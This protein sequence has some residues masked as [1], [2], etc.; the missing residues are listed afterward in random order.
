MAAGRFARPRPVDAP[1]LG[2]RPRQRRFRWPLPLLQRRL[3]L[4]QGHSRPGR[5]ARQPHHGCL[6]R[7]AHEGRGDPPPALAAP[8]PTNADVHIL[9]NDFIRI[10]DNPVEPELVG[11]ELAGPPQP[12]RRLPFLVLVRRRA[13]RLSGISTATPAASRAARAS[14]AQPPTL[15]AASS[16]SATRQPA[17]RPAAEPCRILRGSSSTT[18]GT[19]AAPSS[20]APIPRFRNCGEGPDFTAQLDFFNNAFTWCSPARDGAWV[21]ENDRDAPPFRPDEQPRHD[22]RPRHLRPPGLLRRTAAAGEGRG[23][24]TALPRGRFSSTRPPATSRS[25]ATARRAGTAAVRA[26]PMRRAGQR[27]RTERFACKPTEGSTAARS[28]TTA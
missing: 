26:S 12:P 20:A 17:G 1:R 7:H 10:R 3:P 22:I 16:S 19:C 11:L 15:W 6:Q 24:R 5:R 18:A 8:P 4:R 25:R 9:D 21:C 23:E 2:P 13:R 27:A 28:R 14:R